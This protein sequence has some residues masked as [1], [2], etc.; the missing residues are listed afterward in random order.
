VHGVTHIQRTV[1]LCTDLGVLPKRQW[2][3][4]HAQFERYISSPEMQEKDMVTQ[5]FSYGRDVVVSE[6]DGRLE[7]MAYTQ[8][9]QGLA[10]KPSLMDLVHQK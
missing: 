4:L 5:I 7:S 1:A 6:V 2:T 10:R 9:E 8:A 3:A